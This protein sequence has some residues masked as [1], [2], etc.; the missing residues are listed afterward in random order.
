M[1]PIAGRAAA[2]LATTILAPQTCKAH[3]LYCARSHAAPVV[4]AP[5]GLGG[6][7]CRLPRGNMGPVQPLGAAYKWHNGIMRAISL[8]LA[9]VCRVCIAHFLRYF[10]VEYAGMGHLRLD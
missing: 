3:T 8:N 10:E 6:F 5:R 7:G 1:L 2:P 4:S 9:R